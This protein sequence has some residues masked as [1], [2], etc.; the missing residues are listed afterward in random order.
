MGSSCSSVKKKDRRKAR[1]SS[2]ADS[3]THVDICGQ[4]RCSQRSIESLPYGAKGSPPST[5]KSSQ[6]ET[7]GKSDT[8]ANTEVAA[9]TP[10]QTPKDHLLGVAKTSSPM[11][12]SQTPSPFTTPLASK[13][14]SGIPDLSM[15]PSEV[16]NLLLG[17]KLSDLR[18][19]VAKQLFLLVCRLVSFGDAI[20]TRLETA[21]VDLKE[22][23]FNKGY[24]LSVIDPYLGVDPSLV[25]DHSFNHICFHNF[26]ALNKSDAIILNM[27]IIGSNDDNYFLPSKIEESH[28]NTLNTLIT[29]SIVRE[30]FHKWYRLDKNSL[31]PHYVLQA[32]SKHLPSVL[33]KDKEERSHAFNCWREDL[34]KMVNTLQIHFADLEF[35]N[36]YMRSLLE[37]QINFLLEDSNLIKKCVLVQMDSGIVEANNSIRELVS[38]LDKQLPELQKISI[39]LTSDGHDSL[40][41]TINSYISSSSKSPLIIVGPRGCGKS[42][43]IAKVSV[44]ASLNFPSHAVIYRSVG[45]S[46]E[47]TTQ[48]QILRS[49]CEHI[50]ALYGKHPSEASN[51]LRDNNETLLTLLKRVSDER[52]L[53][54]LIDG[55]DQVVSFRNYDLDLLIKELPPN[56]KFIVTLT[57]GSSL[58]TDLKSRIQEDKLIEMSS[59]SLEENYQIFEKF[60]SDNKR[61]IS[62]AQKQIVT[63]QLKNC[64]LS[65]YAHLI[66]KQALKWHSFDTN[67]AIIPKDISSCVSNILAEGENFLGTFVAHVFFSLLVV[68]KHGLS[69]FQLCTLLACEEVLKNLSVQNTNN[70]PIFYW[71][72][73]IQRLNCLLCTKLIGRKSVYSWKNEFIKNVVKQRLSDDMLVFARK[74]IFNYFRSCPPLLQYHEVDTLSNR[75]QAEEL[76]YSAIYLNGTSAKKEYI[77]NITWLHYKLKASDPLNLVDDIELYRNLHET[78]EE[79]DVFEKIIKFSAYSLRYDGSQILSQIY[80]RLNDLMS[81]SESSFGIKFPNLKQLFDASSKPF[82]PSL[83]P[84]NT[85]F[86]SLTYKD[87][88]LSSVVSSEDSEKTFCS[89]FTINS[90]PSHIVAISPDEGLIIVWNVFEEKIVRKLKGI[91]QPRDVKMVD[92]YRALVLCNRELKLYNLDSGVL[93][94]KL[95]GVMNQKMPFY[96]L[97]DEKYVVALSRNRMYVNMMNIGTGD[98]E[99]QF[100]VGEDRFLNSLL[101]SAN[102]KICVCGDETQKPF[103]LLVWDLSS[104]KLIYDLRIPHHEFITN[105]AAISDDG[106]Y[107]VSVCKE[108]NSS[109][110]NFIIVYD[111]QSG[112]L[113]KKWKP[114]CNTNSIAISSQGGFVLNGV[115]NCRILVWDLSTGAKRHNLCGHSAPV[116]TLQVDEIGK[117]FLSFDS[118]GKDHSIRIWNAESGTCLAVFTPDYPLSCCQLSSNGKLVVFCFKKSTKLYTLL[119]CHENSVERERIKNGEPYGQQENQCQE[120]DLTE[121]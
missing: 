25:D 9:S 75:I 110:P 88:I 100:K 78:S 40:L 74:I 98:L 115:E 34:T 108:L 29:D 72:W 77:F 41:N 121:A 87:Q 58:L 20:T 92:R 120:F 16:R 65:F 5:C 101:V 53:L 57:E 18:L 96:G 84:L 107:V 56:T 109:A 111:L 22:H 71:F 23:C 38:S 67:D 6:Q 60:L 39:P 8:Q 113:F 31:E 21:F 7:S 80:C 106:H 33:A 49:V 117:N 119:L 90:D 59:L 28:F 54:I 82:A 91:N 55:F 89:L 118:S 14:S 45:V 19:P 83:L 24:E 48:E 81:D 70:F 12:L 66:G 47:S 93:E 62:D 116:D 51:V 26:K 69:D 94:S 86:M 52:P 13:P 44:D 112:T 50:C 85:H 99:T 42:A 79:L 68:S 103:P 4:R 27:V 61:K 1:R 105:L 30:L 114:D 15:Y 97:H 36:K 104:R 46:E 11:H 95:K 37:Q 3:G 73:I 76:P 43:L 102:G 63:S 35:H 64:P 17:Q 10:S 32:I 2:S